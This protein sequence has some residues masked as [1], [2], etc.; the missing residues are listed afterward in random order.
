MLAD[1]VEHLQAVESRH[2]HV[3]DDRVERKGAGEVEPFAAI[4]SQPD[5]V[6]LAG[7]QRLENLTHDLLVVDDEDGSIAAHHDRTVNAL[8][9]PALSAAAL[10]RSVKRV[11]CPGAL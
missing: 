11:P 8:P 2:H 6:A 4:R 5:A 7:E 9:R 1:F 10:K 3:D